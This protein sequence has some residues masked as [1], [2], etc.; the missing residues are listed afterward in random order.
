MPT[1]RE[2]CARYADPSLRTME[3]LD[4]MMDKGVVRR[5]FIELGEVTKA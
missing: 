1:C 4:A 3:I 2:V 5:F